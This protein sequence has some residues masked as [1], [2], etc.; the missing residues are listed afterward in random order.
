MLQVRLGGDTRAVRTKRSQCYECHAGL[1]DMM[2][3]IVV[4]GSYV[5]VICAGQF[6]RRGHGSQ[7]FEDVWA[8]VSDIP[9]LDRDRLER[10][11][12]Q[13]AAL[14]EENA[15]RLLRQIE[16]AA[17]NIAELG[18]GT[19]GSATLSGNVLEDEK[20]LGTCHVALGDNSTFGGRVRAPSHLDGVLRRP[21]L[22][23]DGGVVLADGEPVGW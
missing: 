23:L 12:G 22:E 18:L 7:R 19:N 14:D 8:R 6:F 11:Y 1:T 20:V 21:T 2:A 3:P 4:H 15:D 17:R 16:D 9:G 10:A 13:V 5:G